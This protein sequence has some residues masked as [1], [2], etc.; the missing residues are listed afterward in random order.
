MTTRINPN[1]VRLNQNNK[2]IW[3]TSDKKQ[4]V[5]YIVEDIKIR[6]F[7]KKKFPS[8][9]Q[10]HEITCFEIVINR[11]QKNECII[12][13][14]G[15]K[16]LKYILLA[17]KTEDQKIHIA[18]QYQL[19]KLSEELQKLIGN[20]TKFIV[21]FTQVPLENKAIFIASE[22]AKKIEKK[23]NYRLFM[24]ILS[25]NALQLYSGIK[26][27]I[28]G[29]LGAMARKEKKISGNLGE[30]T[31]NNYIET[32]SVQAK[33]VRGIVGVKVTISKKENK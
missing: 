5:S 7:F 22:L 13:L 4:F 18:I 16:E 20:K 14:I 11:N 26:I 12:E 17:H 10:S 1:L 19:S 25:Q 8:S 2:S 15:T 3:F 29:C 30:G 31:F 28:S 21:Q 6:N 23:A 24:T 33:T 32:A 27:E 9:G